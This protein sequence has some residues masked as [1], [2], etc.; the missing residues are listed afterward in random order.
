[1][2]NMY[3]HDEQWRVKSGDQLQTAGDRSYGA[4][5]EPRPVGEI[6]QTLD[7]AGESL[8]QVEALVSELQARLAPILL[9]APDCAQGRTT[10][11]AATDLGALLQGIDMR[12]VVLAQRLRD[13]L[14]RVAL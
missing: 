5:G 12:N 10:E 7:R 3:R 6:Q 9:P 4:L 14:D 13:L 8:H 1:M 2:A 11:Q